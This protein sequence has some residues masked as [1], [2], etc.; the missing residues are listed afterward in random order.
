MLSGRDQGR[1]LDFACAFR[2]MIRQFEN[3]LIEVGGTKLYMQETHFLGH[4]FRSHD[5][6]DDAG[7]MSQVTL[8]DTF[9][10][11]TEIEQEIIFLDHSY[12]KQ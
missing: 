8:E 10:S 9:T 11:Q 7:S 5:A 1:I 2:N 6:I 4:Y 12:S 3:I